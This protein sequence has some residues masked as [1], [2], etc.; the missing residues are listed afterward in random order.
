M[1]K[2]GV[3]QPSNSEC[4]SAPVLVRKRDGSVVWCVDY[5]GLNALT[6]KDACPLP[7]IDESLYTL[8]GNLIHSFQKSMI[9]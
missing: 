5:R 3:V 8:S 4:A 1:E 6:T 2:A 7:Q 9:F